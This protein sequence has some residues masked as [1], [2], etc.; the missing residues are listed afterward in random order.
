MEPLDM[1]TLASLWII[2]LATAHAGYGNED[3]TVVEDQVKTEI[4][5]P[6]LQNQKILKLRLSNGLEAYLISDPDAPQAAASLAVDVGSWAEPQE[7]PGLAHFLEHMLFLGNSKYPEESEFSNFI[8]ER[9]GQSN[10]YT[11]DQQTVYSFS[12]D[13][14]GF[15]PA[16]DRFSWFFRDPLFNDSGID[17]E[18]QAVDQEHAG[19]I[20]N[21]RIREYAILQATANPDH[22]YHRF[23]TGT[24]ETLGEISQDTLKQ[25]YA[26][27]Y[28]ANVMH[29]SI[30]SAQPLE[31]LRD[32]VVE[33]FSGVPNRNTEKQEINQPLLIEHEQGQIIYV[34]PIKDIR[35][36]KL[37]W[38]LP[39][40]FAH[41]IETQ[42]DEV[43]GYTLG[44]EGEESLLAQLKREGLAEGL[45]AGGHPIGR[46]NF[47][48][49]ID[50][51]LT[52]NGL[53]N[54]DTVIE[55]CFQSIA[56]FRNKGIPP[57]V[58]EEM[59]KQRR[60]NFQFPSRE[61][62]YTTA[63]G[64]AA[65]MQWEPLESY[66]ER[67]MIPQRNDEEATAEIVRLLNPSRVKVM[68]VGSPGKTHVQ[69]DRKEKWHGGEYA[70]QTLPLTKTEKWAA[71]T[72]HDK[73]R[74]PARNPFIPDHLG[75]LYKG[76]AVDADPKP[77][78]LS[79]SDGDRIYY[80]QDRRYLVPEV[81]WA[82]EIKT[83][84]VDRYNAESIVLADL[85][86]RSVREALNP[87]A[88]QA[89]LGGLNFNIDR[90]D[91][92][93]KLSIS[94]YSQKAHILLEE[95]LKVIKTVTPTEK[96]F[97]LYK[98]SLRRDYQNFS[99][100]TPL[101]QG[102]ETLRTVVY[103]EYITAAD[104]AK[105]IRKINYKTLL[106]FRDNL[107]KRS[108]I[109]G[110]LY[111][112][113]DERQA[114]A[115]WRELKRTLA[116]LPYSPQ[117]HVPLKVVSLP[118]DQGPYYLSRQVKPAGNAVILMVQ[119][120]PY[121]FKQRA[122]HQVL[123]QAMDRPFFS[124]LRTKQQ[125]GYIVF[126][127]D[128]V[129]EK[130]L[131]SFFAVQSATHDVRDLLARFELWI[132]GFMQELDEVTFPVERFDTIRHALVT[133]LKQP[134]KNLHEQASMIRTFAFEHDADF[135]F[136]KKRVSAF[137]ALTYDDF[138]E[139]A[140]RVNGRL[141]KQRLAI[142]VRGTIDFPEY[143]KYS[144]ASSGQQLKKISGYLSK[145]DIEQE[146]VK[147]VDPKNSPVR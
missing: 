20:E 96:Q 3:Y 135:A 92:G 36:L 40:K 87:L 50:I 65:N 23:D 146:L 54:R 90:S 88:Y 55:R 140:G 124:A 91:E 83:P 105:A 10:A 130:Q 57:Y 14:D 121:T 98:D 84:T 131:F 144:R 27:H 2:L 139:F 127:T 9:S 8:K 113:L 114:R 71:L 136:V 126:T 64:H 30:I 95:I 34:S 132:E 52:E 38:E 110:F 37:I 12:I 72:S 81:S 134:P 43:V 112:N 68:V 4:L 15:G 49:A 73:I 26:Q 106:Q 138:L 6:T 45:S 24:R 103:Q 56:H 123:S 42:P 46:N 111:G 62:P 28:S 122:A 75:L 31:E 147:P 115:V 142:M 104:K 47:I 16:L 29:L 100:E 82:F 116:S 143:L 59:Q 79:S 145:K 19:R 78:L 76:E 80:A 58:F 108:Y 137:E 119:N 129:I 51:A 60:I 101:T 17:R 53:R 118:T 120:G 99:K 107:Y 66:P 61:H 97:S 74:T 35:R 21:D 67:L 128:Q 13:Q 109:E 70:V 39:S 22:P 5:T 133:K 48:F 11:A 85:Y 25:W 63:Q 77:M 89:L 1:R 44:H 93:I 18:M 141:N 125:T 117:D 7:H 32:L 102:M 94:G 86:L 41:M 69:P 33:T